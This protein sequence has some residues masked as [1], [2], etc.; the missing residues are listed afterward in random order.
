MPYLVIRNRSDGMDAVLV[1]R[2]PAEAGRLLDNPGDR[3]V[4]IVPASEAH[5]WVKWGLVHETAL[6]LDDAGKVRRATGCA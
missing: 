1:E 3:H 5:K 4:R 2:T 6:W